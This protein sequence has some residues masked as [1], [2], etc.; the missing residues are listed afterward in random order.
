MI[1]SGLVISR[2]AGSDITMDELNTTTAQ[3]RTFSSEP[4]LQIIQSDHSAACKHLFK[5]VPSV[6]RQSPPVT[7]IFNNFLPFFT[8]QFSINSLMRLTSNFLEK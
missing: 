2:S 4:R 8:A 5:P 6:N 3:A 1:H 7:R